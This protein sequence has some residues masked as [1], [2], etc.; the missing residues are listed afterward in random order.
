M[1]AFGKPAR[2]PDAVQPQMPFAARDEE[3]LGKA[4]LAEAQ[5]WNTKPGENMSDAIAA[6][7][8][9][10]GAMYAYEIFEAIYRRAPSGY[11]DVALISTTLRQM[12]LRGDAFGKRPEPKQPFVYW[13]D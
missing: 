1:T 13:V 2:N 6:V 5:N 11:P 3:Q 10:S 12:I 4:M 8:K 9:R 7:L